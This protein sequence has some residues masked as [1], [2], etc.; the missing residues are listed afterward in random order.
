MEYLILIKSLYDFNKYYR[1]YETRE[2]V[3]VSDE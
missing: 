3:S 1:K 2:W